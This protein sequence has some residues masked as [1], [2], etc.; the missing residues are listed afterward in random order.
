[1]VLTYKQTALPI[2]APTCQG[3]TRLCKIN[4]NRRFLQVLD[5]TAMITL[6]VDLIAD[7]Q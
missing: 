3:I 7:V 4:D 1:M 5:I 2:M 6:N